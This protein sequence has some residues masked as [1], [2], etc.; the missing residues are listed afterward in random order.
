LFSENGFS[1]SLVTYDQT[2]QTLNNFSIKSL[3][4]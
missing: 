2:S 3:I 4:V 1:G